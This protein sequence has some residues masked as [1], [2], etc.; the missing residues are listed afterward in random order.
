VSQDLED[1]LDG[2]VARLL[3]EGA[4][5]VVLTGSHARGE[6]HEHSDV[7]LLFLLPYK[8][9]PHAEQLIEY[10]LYKLWDLGLKV[11]QATRSIA[12]CVR[13][14][15]T[16]IG[17]CTSLLEARFLWGDGPTFDTLRERFESEVVAGMGPVFVEAKLAERDARHQRT[18]DSRYLL[19]PNVKEGKGGLRDLHTLFW[20][21]R[22]LYRVEDPLQLA[23]HGVLTAEALRTFTRAEQFLWA[24]RCHLHYLTG[25]AEER[26]SFDLQRVIADAYRCAG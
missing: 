11:G 21:G 18:G 9:T 1:V 23:A 15:R 4:E 26:L 10:L 6:A 24:V 17:V 5:A 3:G 14:A 7:D 20:L 13:F 25:R 16:D 2:A 12:E 22:F 19:E 8:R